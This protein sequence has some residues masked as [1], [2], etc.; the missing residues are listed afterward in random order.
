[1][2]NNTDFCDERWK[3]VYDI[4]AE[5]E[6]T[7]VSYDRASKA[8][9]ARVEEA[10]KE[11]KEVGKSIEY[12]IKEAV[13]SYGETGLWM[14]LLGTDGVVPLEYLRVFFGLSR[15]SIHAMTC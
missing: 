10:K 13:L 5:G 1:M 2:G 8:R 7:E 14:N 6:A 11:H 3:K 9:Y 4:Y 15:S 12:G